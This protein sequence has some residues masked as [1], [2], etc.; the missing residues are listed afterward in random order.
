MNANH[1]SSRPDWENHQLI[2]RNRLDSRAL[3]IPYADAASALTY[4]RGSSASVRMLNGV[5]KFHYAETPAHAPDRFYE[6][7]YDT[8]SWDDLAVPGSWQ[9]HGYGKPHYTNI[10]YPFPVNPPYVP[11]ENPTGSYVR[12]F[13]V[14]QQ[15]AGKR[16]TLR[17]EG[18]DSAFHVWV[19][20]KFAGFSKGS[21]IPAEF[22]ITDIARTGDNSI[23]VRVYQWSDGS[24]IEDQD[25]WWLSGIFR[26]VY[27]IAAPS[28]ANVE[29]VF[30]RTQLDGGYE[31]AILQVNAKIG[32]RSASSCRLEAQ[33]L[34][35]DYVPVEGGTAEASLNASEGRSAEAELHMPIASPRKWSAENPYLY[36]LLLTLRD[37]NGNVL[38]VVPQRVGFRSVE[39][40]DGNFLVN[41]VAVMLKGVN[42]HD[43]HPDLGKAVP[44]SWMLEDVLLMKR[45]NINAVRTSHYPNDPRF[46]D[47]CDEYGLYVM[48][49]ADL[50]CHG[51]YMT[52]GGYGFEEAKAW[53]TDNPEW[54]AAYLDRMERMVQRDKN[55]PSIIMW[56]VGNE[57][58]FG[59]NHV[60]MY[61]L[62]KRLDPT[63]LIHNEGDREAV[64]SDVYSTMYTGIE[65]LA[66]LGSQAD[67]EKPHIL[68]EYAHA[69]GNGPGGLKEYWETFYAYPRLQGG[70][71]WEW[72]DH[73]IRQKTAEGVEY[74]AYGGDFGDQPNDYN[75]VIDGLVQPDRTPTPGLIEYKKVLE[76]VKIE[77]VDLV[78]GSLKLTNRYDFS[79]LEHLRLSWNV[80]ADGKVI[81]SGTAPS[82]TLAARASQTITL[83]YALPTHAQPGTDYWLNVSFGLASD[84]LWAAAGHEVAWGQW[85]LPV[86]TPA[87]VPLTVS[88]MPSLSCRVTAAT[89]TVE[90]AGF[91][92][93]FDRVYGTI[94][95]WTFEGRNVL[96]DGPKLDF[97]R[98]PTDNDH[99]SAV[100]WRKAGLHALT[101]RIDSFEWRAAEDGKFVVVEVRAHMAPPVLAWSIRTAY[102]YTVYGSGDVV[103]DVSGAPQGGG[104]PATFPR[105]GLR[106]TV[107][108]SLER[109]EWYGRGPGESYSDTK[110]AG[111]IGVYRT[112]TDE[113]YFRYIYPQ[114]NGNR[115]DVRW[116]AFTD[117]RGAGLFAS[118]EAHNGSAAPFNFSALRYDAAEL[119]KAQHTHELAPRSEYVVH[120]D[121]AQHGIGS[122]SCG[123]DVSPQYT[124]TAGEF[125]FG[126]R[127]K[128]FTSDCIS[129]AALGKQ[130]LEP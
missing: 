109:T 66:E 75:F 111:R 125:R 65:K 91:T 67:K 8:R 56:S 10:K 103:I 86:E 79:G 129:P 72:L 89:L 48:D 73:G 100:E 21:R 43:H 49:E 61:E 62:A 11:T 83:P 51:F 9:M 4:D 68:C 15:W 69:M 115:T 7:T 39:L 97:W 55:H 60:A 117:L 29:D 22:D 30:V 64:A 104:M 2:H 63:R 108:E 53:T 34:D 47:L 6:E 25:Q 90:G 128:P 101:T 58:A 12:G 96:N 33:L 99:R 93:T 42:R 98:A 57:S 40:K 13:Q 70:F 46:Y 77:P 23:G 110:L 54:E 127:L 26:D 18:V 88:A 113:L 28:G 59:R 102:T 78:K 112:P 87:S 50:E 94:A 95:S 114:E 122:A 37:S 80:T 84:T 105:I 35:A 116:V 20:G 44:L 120:L 106:L 14:P 24:Y 17:F 16:I 123:P 121:F 41:G 124:L 32:G 126:I 1:E 36:H 92:L 130:T 3:F 119:E 76:P 74:F 38:Q 85:Q 107:P 118:P 82:V 5:W 52:E 81:Q 27:L 45:H 19:N 71:V 31:H